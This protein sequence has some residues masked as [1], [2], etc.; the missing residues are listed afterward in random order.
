MQQFQE[1]DFEPL[2]YGDID[3]L[4]N[5]GTVSI[6][7]YIS[8]IIKQVYEIQRPRKMK[9]KRKTLMNGFPLYELECGV[10]VVVKNNKGMW[11][12]KPSHQ[13]MNELSK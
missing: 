6:P 9:V 8:R 11:L 10:G 1:Q 7:P 2:S 4:K 12:I 5:F 3:G 13:L